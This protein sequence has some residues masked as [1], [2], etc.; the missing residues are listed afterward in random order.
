MIVGHSRRC[1][2]VPR[3]VGYVIAVVAL[4]SQ[5]TLGSL[6]LPDEPLSADRIAALEAASILCGGSASPPGHGTPVRQRTADYALCPLS[7]LLAA[8]AALLTSA[9]C[10]PPPAIG[11]ALGQR[12]RPRARA[13]PSLEVASAYPRGPPRLV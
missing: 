1:R 2:F 8:P 6:A 11:P 10:L 3:L 5:L 9:P 4:V 7:V 12:H 13:P